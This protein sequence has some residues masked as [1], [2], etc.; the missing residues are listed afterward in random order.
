MTPAISIIVPVYNAE[1][2]LERCVRSILLQDFTDFELLL[3]DDGSNSVCSQLCDA[4]AAR[5]P[6]IRVFHT[7]NGGTS[8]ARNYGLSQAAGHYIAFADSDDYVLENWLSSMYDTAIQENADIVKIGFYE[9]AN[10]AYHE[11]AAGKITP[12]AEP[13]S[14]VNYQ[15]K[16][17]NSFEFLENLASQGF[18][19]VWNQLVKK[20]LFDGCRFPDGHLAEDVRICSELCQIAEKNRLPRCG[21]LLLCA[22]RFQSAPYCV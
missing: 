1:K 20:E 6:R 7:P 5:D 15:H 12:P 16:S 3:V 14:V 13:F 9:V 19:C 22:A 2:Y 8:T 17:I 4:L 11:T 10:D 21:C 18:G